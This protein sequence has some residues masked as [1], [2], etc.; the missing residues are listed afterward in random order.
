MGGR[1]RGKRRGGRGRTAAALVLLSALAAGCAED[2]TQVRF[3]ATFTDVNDDPAIAPVCLGSA[4]LRGYVHAGSPQSPVGRISDVPMI[5]NSAG[6]CQSMTGILVVKG[7]SFGKDRK[8]RLEVLDS[9]GQVLGGGES[10]P[11]NLSEDGP[12]DSDL[13][14]FDVQLSRIATNPGTIRLDFPGSTDFEPLAGGVLGVFLDGEGYEERREIHL[15][16]DLAEGWSAER[17]FLS[18]LPATDAVTAQIYG[19]RED[20]RPSGE[21]VSDSFAVGTASPDW[22]ITEVPLNDK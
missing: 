12:G 3:N 5:L 1:A 16:A 18:D 14:I 10:A 21:W 20:K 8:L 11:V 13:P 15:P 2:P 7:V 17:L 9:S 22:V 4:W 6:R 19:I